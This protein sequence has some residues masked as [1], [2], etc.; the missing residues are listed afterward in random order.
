MKQNAL[1][2]PLTNQDQRQRGFP[3]GYT[4]FHQVVFAPKGIKG[5]HPD[6][7]QGCDAEGSQSS[8]QLP[9]DPAHLTDIYLTGLSGNDSC[10]KKESHF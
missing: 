6:H 8:G 4:A 10:A 9:A 1:I 7:T 5:H 2:M 3:P